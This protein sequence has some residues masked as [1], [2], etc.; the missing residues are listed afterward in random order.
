MQARAFLADYYF[1]TGNIA[2]AENQVNKFKNPRANY[3]SQEAKVIASCVVAIIVSAKDKE[4]AHNILNYQL[5]EI[6]KSGAEYL[7][8][9]LLE[10]KEQM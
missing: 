7:K 6:D 9:Q 4:K 8:I 10:L 5:Q 1:L 2:G 3:F